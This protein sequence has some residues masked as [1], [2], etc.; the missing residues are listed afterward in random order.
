VYCT[1][2]GIDLG[3]SARFCSSCGKSLADSSA[4][5]PVKARDWD[6]HINVL[7]WLIIAHSA[8]VGAIGLIVM[9]GGS[10]IRNLIRN[11]PQLLENANPNDVPP[12]EVL[13]ILAPVSF[14]IG[15]IFLLIALPSIIAGVGLLRYRTWGRGLTLV[16]SFLRLLEFP[17]GTATAVYSFWI[18]LSRDG[19]RFYNEKAAQAEA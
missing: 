8:L 2:C 6:L 17:F 1:T 16:L 11:N 9:V 12:P 4:T 3:A 19:K 10:F 13:A 15:L 7:G 5:A 14:M 18:L